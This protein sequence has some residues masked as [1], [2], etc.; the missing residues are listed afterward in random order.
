[1]QKLVLENPYVVIEPGG[2][3]TTFEFT[4]TTP[5]F[6]K[7]RAFFQNAVGYPRRCKNLQLGS[8]IAVVNN[9]NQT[10]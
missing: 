5:A 3:P 2:N 8:C 4:A 10:A 6:K 7:A 9:T 1:V